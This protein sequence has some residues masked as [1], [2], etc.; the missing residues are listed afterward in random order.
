M[1]SLPLVMD[2]SARTTIEA[3]SSKSVQTGVKSRKPRRLVPVSALS[4]RLSVLTRRR[5]G[6]PGFWLT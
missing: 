3:Y 5:C 4:E 6:S 1:S 2:E